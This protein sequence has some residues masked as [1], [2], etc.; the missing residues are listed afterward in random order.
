M[1]EAAEEGQ[2]LSCFLYSR[3][4]WTQHIN[5]RIKKQLILSFGSIGYF[6]NV[7]LLLAK[8]PKCKLPLTQR[9]NSGRRRRIYTLAFL[10]FHHF[11]LLTA[12]QGWLTSA[13][14]QDQED[15]WKRKQLH[16][17]SFLFLFNPGHSP[18]PQLGKEECRATFSVRVDHETLCYLHSWGKGYVSRSNWEVYRGMPG[19]SFIWGRI[20][21]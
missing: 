21:A 16:L 17:R 4:N 9:S 7:E 5:G 18:V 19:D 15:A 14:F 20:F 8:W 6:L 3:E 10:M 13:C 2:H 11:H 1:V 12:T